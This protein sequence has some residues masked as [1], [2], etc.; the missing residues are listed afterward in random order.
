M[1]DMIKEM[2]KGSPNSLIVG[3]GRGLGSSHNEICEIWR[4]STSRLKIGRPEDAWTGL[5]LS[6]CYQLYIVVF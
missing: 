5:W 4:F 6:P 3:P 2:I 1:K